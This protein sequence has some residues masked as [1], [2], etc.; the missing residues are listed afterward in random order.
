MNNKI[1]CLLSAAP[2]PVHQRGAGPAVGV[3]V[4]TGAGVLRQPP[5]HTGKEHCVSESACLV[6]S[7]FSS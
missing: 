6:G 2:K 7:G 3:G 1:I 4:W 5:G